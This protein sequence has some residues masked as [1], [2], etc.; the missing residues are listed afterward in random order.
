M[1]AEA[2]I[3]IRA[4]TI[5]LGDTFSTERD[6]ELIRRI[7]GALAFGAEF[8]PLTHGDNDRAI[9]VIFLATRETLLGG[10]PA[11][12]R[13]GQ[14]RRSLSVHHLASFAMQALVYQRHRMLIEL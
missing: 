7:I 9:D 12:L 10:H 4:S 14:F 2:T 3:L 5:G 13:F 11:Y 8:Q 6:A 1:F